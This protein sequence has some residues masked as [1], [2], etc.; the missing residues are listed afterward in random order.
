MRQIFVIHGGNTYETREEFLEY[1][2]TEPVELSRLKPKQDWKANLQNTLGEDYE[3]Y[4]PQMPNKQS[5]NYEEWKLWFE[6]IIPLMSDNAIL[7]GH[8]LGGLFLAKYLSEETFPLQLRGVF[9]IAPPFDYDT[10]SSKSLASFALPETLSAFA[11]QVKMIQLYHSA[12]DTV[13]PISNL[14]GYQKALPYARASVFADRGH[15][16]Q[17]SFPELVADIKALG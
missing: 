5:A 14:A 1:L 13:V 3:V 6:R 16:N 2:R 10:E 7:V 8:S 9:L 11:D 17:E 15:F 4:L 12:D